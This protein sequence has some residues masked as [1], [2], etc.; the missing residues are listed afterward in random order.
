MK[1]RP[2]GGLLLVVVLTLGSSVAPASWLGWTADVA[3]VVRAPIMP[4]SRFGTSIAS[5]LR[6]PRDLEGRPVNEVEIDQLRQDRNRF[7]QL[8]QAQRVR[9]DDFARQLRQ[10]EGLPAD[11]LRSA[12]PP[13]VIAA[14]ITGRD[15]SDPRSPIELRMPR[16]GGDRLAVGD[17]AVWGGHYV[18]GRLSHVS[19]MRLMVLPLSNP[20]S[21]PIEVVP[22]TVQDTTSLPRMLLRQEG[23][24]L[25]AADID[26]R[27]VIEP[28]MRL[29]LA[30]HRWP[31]WAQGMDVAVVVRIESLDEAPLRQRII[32]R[33]AVDA[34]A[35]SR[36]VVLSANGEASP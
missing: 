14:D 6:P 17:V 33:P 30:D 29:V 19:P 9:A 10:L 7:E 22:A 23:R 36:V 1:S 21:G 24:G 13:L 28:G 31:A 11:A 12:H 2:G 34:P 3:D 20:E 15:P 5:W 35:V 27:V 18:L 26:R 25:L 32:A 16:D 8:W 4:V